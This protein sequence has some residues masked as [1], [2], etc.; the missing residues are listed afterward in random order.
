MLD[1]SITFSTALDNKEL[2]KQ[3]QAEKAKIKEIEKDLREQERADEKAR[4]AAADAEKALEIQRQK[5]QEMQEALER[6]KRARDEIVKKIDE[7]EQA[8]ESARQKEKEQNAAWREGVV[9][10]DRQASAAK[11]QADELISAHSALVKSIDPYEKKVEKATADMEKQASVVDALGEKHRA[12]TVQVQTTGLAVTKTTSDLAVAKEH[13]GGVVQQLEA[14]NSASNMMGPAIQRANKK[15]EVFKSRLASVV[16]SALVFTVITQGLAKFREWIGKVVLANADASAAMARLKGSLLTVVQPLIN[17]AI[18]AFTAFVDVLTGVVDQLAEMSA[19]MF[20]TTIDAA[21]AAA[22]A[23]YDQS[24]AL[25]KTGKSASKAGKQLAGFD[26]IN[27]IGDESSS[28]AVSADFGG[29]KTGNWL[30]ESLGGA[31]GMVTAA[32][33]LGGIALVAIGAATG[34]ILAIIAG[35][36]LLGV[37]VQVGTSTGVLQK[38]AATLGLRSVQEFVA[39]AVI[40]GGIA[41]VAIGAA[42][43]NIL[44]VIA[45]LA[46]IGVSIVYAQKSGMM[47]DWA[48][49][50]GLSRAASFIT[51]ALLLG[52]IALVAIGAMTTNVLMIIAGIGLIGAGV[53][54]GAESGTLESWAKALGLDSVFDY[55]VA[56]IQLAGI[57]LIAIGAA[58]ANIPLIIAGAAL[59]TVG[60]AADAAGQ[61][62]L[63]SWWDVLKLTNAQQ[64]VSAAI[65][66]VG[67]AL[68]AIGA[69]MGN[70]LMILGG[71]ALVAFGT[72]IAVQNGNLKNWVDVLGLREVMTWITSA[73]LLAGI[74]L[75][76][77][78]IVTA[79]ILMAVAGIGLL[80]AGVAIGAASAGSLKKWWETLML[81]EVAGWVQTALLLG[82]IALV[83]IGAATGN[84]AFVLAGLGLLGASIAV[85]AQRNAVRAPSGSGGGGSRSFSVQSMP[86]MPEIPYLAQGAVIPPNRK[87][88]AVLGDQTSGTN[89]E[90]PASEIE[91]A[92]TRGIAAAGGNG[93][94]FEI[95]IR[96]APGMT[97]Y[98]SYE[99]DDESKRRGATLVKE[100]I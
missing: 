71:M 91:N 75:L 20:G 21:R 73:L 100:N 74:A 28:N 92:V 34:N 17:I 61:E 12:A 57:A 42:M 4:K 72:V 94:R 32:L 44:M 65:L 93:Q 86:T 33:L 97:R 7:S 43:S 63:Q 84:L 8:I 62:T 83:A 13:A 10:A 30:Q 76:V 40:L 45:G 36:A 77:F 53:Y 64:W 26:K 82:G 79:N 19:I 5:Q 35:L 29:A 89:I 48:S 90:A 16:R 58:M 15:L 22:S 31:A 68:I 66:L 24:S 1:G 38:W 50:L 98:L 67:I 80:G 25:D 88:L 99:L 69:A 60:I 9:G 47:A 41:I 55:V 96:P 51:A 81:S 2:E 49:S 37:A 23:L 14:A 59:L 52:G 18:P 56:G 11:E 39:T 95:I 27:K 3:L 54:V 85:G 70:I 6:E 46:L 78:G 87:F